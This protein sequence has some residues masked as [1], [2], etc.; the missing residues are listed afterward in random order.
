M[1]ELLIIVVAFI[2]LL[3]II[4]W[5]HYLNQNRQKVKIDNS[6][7]DETNVRLYHE[8]KAEIER[9]FQ[10]GGL[11][12]ESYEYLI[13]E[14]EQ[15]LLQDIQ[16]NATEANQINDKTSSLSMIWPAIIS[17]FIIVFSVGL[18]NERGS[19]ELIANTPK[20]NGE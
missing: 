1:L 16:D 9:D 17:L 6:F 11:A 18:Y 15:S 5:A 4:V 19:M 13:A 8:H 7:R 10:Q 14:L 3:L 12:Q 2:L 20:A